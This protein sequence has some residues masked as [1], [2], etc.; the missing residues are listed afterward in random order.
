MNLE[1]SRWIFELG[2]FDLDIVDYFLLVFL[3]DLV[4]WGFLV[5]FEEMSY[6]LD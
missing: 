2:G 4:D 5:F 1:N 3:E 6:L